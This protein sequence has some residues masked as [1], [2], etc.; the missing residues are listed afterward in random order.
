MKGKT[1]EKETLAAENITPAKFSQVACLSW[2]QYL[3]VTF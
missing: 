1:R 3:L 2:K